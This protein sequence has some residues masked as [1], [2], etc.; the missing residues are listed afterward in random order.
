M[1]PTSA[2]YPDALEATPQ[3]VGKLFL[4]SIETAMSSAQPFNSESIKSLSLAPTAQALPA[5]GADA[6]GR[7]VGASELGTPSVC[8]RNSC[9]GLG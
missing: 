2:A 9:C 5:A 4:L 6:P 8:N 7:A 3:P 1:D